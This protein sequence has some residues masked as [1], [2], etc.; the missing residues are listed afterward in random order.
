MSTYSEKLKDP[1]WQKKR[2]EILQRDGFSC[3]ICNDSTTTLHVHHR[4]YLM[5]RDPWDYP[6]EFFVTLCAPC[7][8]NET[9]MDGSASKYLINILKL[10]GFFSGDLGIIATGVERMAMSHLSDVMAGA[11]KHAFETPDLWDFIVED[12]INSTQRK[13]NGEHLPPDSVEAREEV[14]GD[15]RDQVGSEG[16]ALQGVQGSV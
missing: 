9:E 7:H 10:Q 15:L 12:Y 11:I 3:K 13:S 8:E 14:D 2:L 1:R 4:L 16:A 6:D 5:G